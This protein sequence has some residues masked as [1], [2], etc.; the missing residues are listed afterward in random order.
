MV[1]DDEGRQETDDAGSTADGEDALFL[2]CLE[3]RSGLSSQLD[4]DHQPEPAD[5]AHGR[6][7]ETPQFLDAND[8]KTVRAFPQA[9]PDGVINRGRPGR[10][11]ERI[12]AERGIVAPLRSEERRVGK[13]CRSRW[14][15]YH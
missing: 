2:Q 11:S 12:P 10:T 8:P 4:A 13:E 9:L 5:L 7:L 14:S 15:P 3:D 6:R 1:R